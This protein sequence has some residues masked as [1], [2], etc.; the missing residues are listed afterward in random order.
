MEPTFFFFKILFIYLTERE[1]E[2]EKRGE[3]EHKKV[4][5]AEG[6]TDT[7]LSRKPDAGLIP[8]P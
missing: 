8:G 6:E 1:R 4:R 5:G 2:R 7:P 3:R